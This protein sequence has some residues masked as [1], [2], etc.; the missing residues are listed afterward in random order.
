MY[1]FKYD[2]RVNLFSDKRCKNSCPD[3]RHVHVAT[4]IFQFKS[5][6][7]D[8]INLLV[9]GEVISDICNDSI[10]LPEEWALDFLVD[11]M[12]KSLKDNVFY[13]DTHIE[14]ELSLTD[15]PYLF[16]KEY[17]FKSHG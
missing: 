14:I 9:L 6:K 13:F 8:F 5:E 1:I 16:K 17:E 12:V 15:Y 4:F 11:E 3:K 10:D 7:P 2:F